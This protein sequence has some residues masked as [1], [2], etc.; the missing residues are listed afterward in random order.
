MKRGARLIVDRLEVY[1]K[2]FEANTNTLEKILNDLIENDG[3]L[4]PEECLKQFYDL[5]ERYSN[6]ITDQ[7]VANNR[8]TT[9]TGTGGDSSTAYHHSTWQK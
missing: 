3:I 5:A 1:D 6:Q 9:I 8:A 2:V 7:I 4:L